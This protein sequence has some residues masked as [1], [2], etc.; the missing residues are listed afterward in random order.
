MRAW[1]SVFLAILL[2]IGIPVLMG[3]GC[4][5]PLSIDQPT[6]IQIGQQAATDLEKQYGV[7]NDPA[8]T[9]RIN[10]I[11]MNIARNTPR[12]DLP[13][14]F[15]IL[16]D[17]SVNALSLP[18]GF[19]YVTKGLMDLNVPDSELAGV[20]GHESAH[21]VERH[22]VKAIQ[23]SMQY[24]LLEELVLGRSSQSVQTA[25]NLSVQYGL[26]LPHSREDE[27]QADLVGTKLAYN[28]GNPSNGLLQFLIRLQQ[29]TGPSSTPGWASTHPLTQDRITREQQLVATLQNARRP[30]PIVFIEET[31]A[32]KPESDI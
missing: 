4:S 1:R 13:W 27:Y 29:L 5:S 18:G 28:A 32:V 9:A 6:E 11:G 24:S 7:V 12:A 3:S 14:S 10:R 26:E 31:P 25:A 8:G 19:V 21:V 2:V 17:S 23:R 20:L 15:K 22:S 30:V 16:N